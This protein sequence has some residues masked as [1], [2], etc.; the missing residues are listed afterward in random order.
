MRSTTSRPCSNGSTAT[1]TA[2]SRPT[3]SPARKSDRVGNPVPAVV[4]SVVVPAVVQAVVQVAVPVV[5]RDNPVNAAVVQQ[6]AE[7]DRVDGPVLQ[8]AVAVRADGPVLPVAEVGRADGPVLP[9]AEVDRAD[10][11]VLQVAVAVR[12]DGPVQPV[13]VAVRADG[14]D[15]QGSQANPDGP[16]PQATR[17]ANR[18]PKPSSSGLT[19]TRTES[20]KA[21]HCPGEWPRCLNAATPTR[22][23]HSTR[24]NSR[25][26][27]PASATGTSGPVPDPRAAIVL[28]GPSNLAAPSGIRSLAKNR[29][30]A[31]SP[32]PKRRSKPDPPAG[33][34]CVD[35]NRE[36]RRRPPG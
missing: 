22:M 8:V 26:S 30:A 34:L 16:V 24:V 28:N 27:S 12:A 32:R 33:D 10:G 9:V 6:V 17:T 14:P 35:R 20:S 29:P 5:S 21:P 31:R 11:P 1:A 15:Q 23:V 19:A 4:A 25:S 18:A 7:V 2:G 3:N 36:N 13:A